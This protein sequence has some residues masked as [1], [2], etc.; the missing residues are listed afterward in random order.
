MD[1]MSA[2]NRLCTAWQLPGAGSADRQRTSPFGRT[3][4]EDAVPICT[5]WNDLNTDQVD[6][7]TILGGSGLGDQALF[8]SIADNGVALS[9]PVARS[10]QIDRI[11]MPESQSAKAL[12]D[13]RA[14]RD[15]FGPTSREATQA[16]VKMQQA[17][18]QENININ[19]NKDQALI[20]V[21]LL[22]TMNHMESQRVPGNSDT[23][24]AQNAVLDSTLK[25]L[26]DRY[27]MT[28]AG[29]EPT[30]ANN[31]VNLDNPLSMDD[32]IEAIL[33]KPE[34]DMAAR[35]YYGDP[36]LPDAFPGMGN[37]ESPEAQ[38]GLAQLV[39]VLG[40]ES[41]DFQEIAILQSLKQ[42]NNVEQ[43][44]GNVVGNI[45]AGPQKDQ[46]EARK[47]AIRT[48]IGELQKEYKEIALQQ[49]IF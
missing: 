30:T 17:M 39:E 33:S 2:Q 4:A 5:A 13:Y 37:P 44:L 15:Q 18:S 29:Q 47:S 1:Y 36:E 3:P 45:D 11:I 48:S 31:G 27:K 9:S 25:Q 49:P 22:E 26:E 23:A 42:L 10:A 12:A 43:A 8:D 19:G 34:N 21:M 24:N 14:A 40:P 41:S 38:R 28:V 32:R 46:I 20:E 6:L 16:S 35:I 7:S